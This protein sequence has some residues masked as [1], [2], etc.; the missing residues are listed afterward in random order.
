MAPKYIKTL[1]VRTR[2]KWRAWLKKHGDSE[3]EIWLIYH[4]RHTGIPSVSY[5][6]SV[7]EALCFGWIDSI[8]KRLDDDRYARKFTPRKPDSAWSTINRRRYADLKSR[9]LL[10][11]AG[12]ERPPTNRSGDAPRPSTSTLPPDL[13]RQIKANAQAKRFFDVL[14]PSYRRMCITWIEAA[15]RAETR[16]KRI[17]EVIMMLAARRKPGL[18]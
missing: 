3:S 16:Q 11:S 6:D 17:R 10:A 9:G 15:K 14:A 1:D 5:G 12:L 2:P 18:K 13:E 7:E 4:K 8:I